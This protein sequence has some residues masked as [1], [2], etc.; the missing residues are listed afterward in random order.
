[1]YIIY[2]KN[3]NIVAEAAKLTEVNGK[4]GLPDEYNFHQNKILPGLYT[5]DKG[6]YFIVRAGIIQAEAY[7]DLLRLRWALFNP[8][9][10]LAAAHHIKK[11]LEE[12]KRD[13]L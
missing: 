6:K 10:T 13:E 9:W 11:A 1:M 5:A 7:M 12:F 4:I 8:R 2:D 3:F